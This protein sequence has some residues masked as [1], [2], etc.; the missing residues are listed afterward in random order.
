M[1]RILQW[2]MGG[3]P[4]ARPP[5]PHPNAPGCAGALTEWLLEYEPAIVA[6]QEV[7][8]ELLALVKMAPY[9]IQRG[10]LGFAVLVRRQLY[11]TVKNYDL[12]QRVQVVQLD[13]V[14]RALASLVV[15]NVH[16]PVLHK[17]E[18]DRRDGNYLFARDIVR[19]VVGA[20]TREGIIVGD[21][22]LPP[23]DAFIVG[24]AGLAANRDLAHAQ[25]SRSTAEPAFY[26]ASW[27]IFGG[28]AGAA[29][30]YYRASV[31]HGPWQVPDQLLLSPRLLEGRQFQVQVLTRLTRLPGYKVCT[32]GGR[33]SKQHTSD[34]L[35]VLLTIH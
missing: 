32:S 10:P 25:A 21:F 3:S 1:L 4:H 18:D 2:N 27:T 26:N 23:Y 5:K 30:T 20:P 22:N 24:R 15:F 31:P 8:D 34:H 11:R 35:P 28:A 9:E 17:D 6:L 19:E 13:G 33:P 12:R 7:T 29:G 16:L 14:S